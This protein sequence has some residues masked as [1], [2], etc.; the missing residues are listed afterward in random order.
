MTKTMARKQ[1][2]GMRLVASKDLI[3]SAIM[4]A[5]ARDGRS[6]WTVL[7]NRTPEDYAA[8]TAAL[9]ESR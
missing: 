3:K 5:Q 7:H 4:M 9:E 8:L 1:I 2:H 6:R